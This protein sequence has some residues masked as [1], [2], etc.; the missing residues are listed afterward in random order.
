MR[1]AERRR[2]SPI[3][4]KRQKNKAL[5]KK[6]RDARALLLEASCLFAFAST[7][8]LLILDSVLP[9][10]SDSTVFVPGSAALPSM[11]GVSMPVPGSLTFL[12]MSFM[13]DVYV[14]VSE[15]SALLFISSVSVAMPG[16]LTPQSVSGVA[17]SVPTSSVSPFV[18][19]ISISMPGSS[20]S[21]FMSSMFMSV[22]DC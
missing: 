4:K 21:L 6:K 20:I 8:F 9:F 3:Q 13:S 5:G 16:L 19:A 22:P 2:Q 18:F 10:A 12:F 11:S 15:P 14:L 7:V 17:V 1:I